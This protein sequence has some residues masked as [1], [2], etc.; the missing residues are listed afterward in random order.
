MDRSTVY[1]R[2]CRTIL[3]NTDKNYELKRKG[4]CLFDGDKTRGWLDHEWI[5]EYGTFP[6]SG[7]E[8]YCL[9]ELR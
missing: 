9:S 3:Y 5:R 1:C 2:N 8:F 7:P 4:L 6:I